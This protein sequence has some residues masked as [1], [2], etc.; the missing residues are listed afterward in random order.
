MILLPLTYEG[1][2]SLHKYEVYQCFTSQ[3]IQKNKVNTYYCL[4]RLLIL[5]AE[6]RFILYSKIYK[7]QTI[8]HL[9]L[10]K[11]LINHYNLMSLFAHKCFLF[12]Y[13]FR[14]QNFKNCNGFQ[15][16]LYLKQVIFQRIPHYLIQNRY[17][18]FQHQECLE[19][20]FSSHQVL[21]EV[22][23]YQEIKLLKKHSKSNPLQRRH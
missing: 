4:H 16:Y 5:S 23:H 15:N 12:N 18:E 6:M 1:S 7:Q 9:Y 19:F 14:F 10:L 8:H 21:K 22:L 13:T 11:A 2:F 20:Q 3:Y 17:Q